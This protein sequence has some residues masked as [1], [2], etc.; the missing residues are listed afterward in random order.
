MFEFFLQQYS[1]RVF[2]Y[3]KNVNLLLVNLLYSN[4]YGIYHYLS[5]KAGFT[6][7]QIK[8]AKIYYIHNCH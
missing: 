2:L 5:N 7:S 6:D 3:K 4:R 1:G 8:V